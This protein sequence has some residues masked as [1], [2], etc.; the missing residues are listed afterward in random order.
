MNKEDILKLLSEYL[1]QCGLTHSFE[2]FL[3]SKGLVFED[4]HKDP[5]KNKVRLYKKPSNY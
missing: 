4:L 1:D 5:D 2:S 3:C